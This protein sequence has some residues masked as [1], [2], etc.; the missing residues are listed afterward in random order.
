MQFLSDQHIKW[1]NA[2]HRRISSSAVMLED[3][4]GRLL[5]V[6]ANYKPY[7][8]LPGGMVDKDETPKDAAIREVKEEVALTLQPEALEFVAVVDRISD[9]TQ[10][11]QFLFKAKLPAENSTIILQKS[12][13][14][15]FAFVTRSQVATNDR[16]YAKAI[17]HW[18]DGKIGY[19]EQTLEEGE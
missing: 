3:H 2:Q 13:I 15:D 1:M 16:Q 9:F 6:K 8:T 12:E 11:Y 4:D 10:T 7:W 5:I 19:I 18:A 14:D 17:K